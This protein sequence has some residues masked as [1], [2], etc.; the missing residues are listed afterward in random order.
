MGWCVFRNSFWCTSWLLRYD[1]HVSQKGQNDYTAQGCCGWCN[2]FAQRPPPWW[3]LQLHNA[4]AALFAWLENGNT[5]N[6]R[7]NVQRPSVL[8]GCLPHYAEGQKDLT[9]PIRN[10]TTNVP[11]E[12][13]R[14]TRQFPTEMNIAD[15]VR[16]LPPRARSS[17]SV[18][19]ISAPSHLYSC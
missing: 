11:N 17:R 12:C 14:H 2:V 10:R 9:P 1:S 13:W 8:A 3:S 6:Q 18:G 15:L 19:C 5:M 4:A 7:L 16:F